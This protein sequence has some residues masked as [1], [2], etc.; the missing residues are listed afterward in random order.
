MKFKNNKSKK[1]KNYIKKISIFFIFLKNL[2][3]N[4]YLK[5]FKKNLKI[6]ELKTTSSLKNNIIKNLFKNSIYSKYKILNSHNLVIVFF[7]SLFFRVIINLLPLKLVAIKLNNRI[8][9][10]NQLNNNYSLNYIC[11]KFLLFQSNII[12]LKKNS[13]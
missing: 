6:F 2:S 12:Y 10:K 7:K 13:K 4:D 5:D 1:I 9:H 3:N 8:Y 11:N